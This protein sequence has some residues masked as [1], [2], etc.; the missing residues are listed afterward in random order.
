VR[1]IPVRN[2]SHM[3]NI[4]TDVAIIGAGAAG[5][6]AA[7]RLQE[8]GA[9]FLV[10]EARERVGGRAY[11]FGSSGSVPIELGAEFIHGAHQATLSLIDECGDSVMDTAW[12]VFQLREGR[13]EETPDMWEAVERIL[14]RVDLRAPD[15]SVETFLDALPSAEF[16]REDVEMVRSLVEGFDAAVTT[17]ASIV[18]IASEWRGAS[19]RSS[20]RP[21]D[22]YAKLIHYLAGIVHSRILL[23]TRVDEVHW[24]SAGVQIYAT[25]F[26][27]RIKINARRAIITLPIGVLQSNRPAFTPPLPVAKRSAIN[28]IR[29]GPVMKVVLD[30]RSPF[31]ENVEN[32]RF[33]DA[34]VFH[35]PRCSVRTLWTRLPQRAPLLVA[36]T[37]GGAAQALIDERQ[38]PIEAALEM[39]GALFP[40]VDVHAQLRNAY[41]HDWQADPFACGAYSFVRVG[42]G[43]ARDVLAVPLDQ[44]LFFAGEA[45]SSDDS[46]TV[47][48]AIDS[49]YRAAGEIAL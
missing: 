40:S 2:S 4:A 47:G 27:H 37:G 6:A 12:Q 36:W 18:A 46:G 29:M 45:T 44:T 26:G 1:N 20:F 42:A 31:W 17:D 15:Q 3:G 30:F 5:L 25:R 8:R 41:F 23:Q 39:C 16:S 7:R 19:N 33:R 24:S 13:L 22:G 34:G 28:D 48:G 43:D 49:G 9:D 32:A 21:I 10:L 38:N 14:Q 11:T 35:A